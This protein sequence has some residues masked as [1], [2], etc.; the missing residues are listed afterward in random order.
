MSGTQ[1]SFVGNLAAAARENPLAAALIGGGALWLL[2]GNEKLKSAASSATAAAAPL[3]DG[4]RNLR[5]GAVRSEMSDA[6]TAPAKT[7]G[8]ATNRGNETLSDITRAASDAMS[9]T[10]DTIKDRF[11]EG[12]TY[13]R[14]NLSKLGSPFPG[15]EAFTQA[16]SSLSEV[17]E[18][19]PLVLGVLGLAIG[20]AVAG[21]FRPSDLE[22]DWLGGFSDSFK[23]DLNVRAG[24][25]SQSMREAADTLKAEL[26]DAGAESV[27]RLQQAGLD[28]LDA[29]TGKRQVALKDPL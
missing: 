25:A 23:T 15:K 6:D 19:Q 10:A 13:A 5:S 2:I 7:R 17:F 24:A 21:A 14:E 3:V 11:D 1:T 16:Q 20:A 8:E 28:A 12:V 27:E 29:A 4:A 9:G 26:G 22:N 18:R